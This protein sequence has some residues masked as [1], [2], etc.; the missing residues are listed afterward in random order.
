MRHNLNNSKV[1]KILAMSGFQQSLRLQ[2]IFIKYFP[3]T[4]D[5]R[6]GECVDIL[7]LGRCTCEELPVCTC[8]MADMVEMAMKL[9][10]QQDKILKEG[11]SVTE[12]LNMRVGAVHF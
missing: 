3:L 9:I 12:A 7:L 1:A 5:C 11:D 2:Q 10:K 6:E 8:T 4:V